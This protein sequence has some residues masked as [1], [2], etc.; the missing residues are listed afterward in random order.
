[1]AS[2]RRRGRA[3]RDEYAG[4]AATYDAMASDPAIA[5]FYAEWRRALAGA[6]RERGLR[7]R[8]LV[9][10][11][12]GTGNSTVPWSRRNRT[13][14]GV[15]KSAAMLREA[16][17]KSAQVRWVRQD[18]RSLR[19]GVTADAVTCHFDALNHVLKEGDLQTVFHNAARLL[20]DGGLFMFDLNTIHMLRWLNGR[21]KM[22]RVDGGVFMAANAFDEATG[23]AT[24]RQTWFL[25]RGRLYERRDI[26][27]RE[28]AYRDA[29]LRAMLRRAGF[30]LIRM[31]AQRAI[32][33]KP[34]RKLYLAVKKTP[35]RI[36]RG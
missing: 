6:A 14:V 21:E 15:D 4:L 34:I 25:E 1:M 20:R 12:C 18:L 22:F 10:L 27:V 33:G 23:I 9:D 28:R 30:R 19:L 36:A 26:E 7:I 13:V 8:V 11:A 32:G 3:A 35:G 29:D 31:S 17:R 16:R 5:A 2:N 24:F